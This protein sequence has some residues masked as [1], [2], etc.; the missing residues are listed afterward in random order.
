MYLRCHRNCPKRLFLI[1]PEEDGTCTILDKE[2][3]DILLEADSVDD[4]IASVME[5]ITASLKTELSASNDVTFEEGT[6]SADPRRTF[7][8]D[9]FR[10]FLLAKTQD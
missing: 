2:S 3:G 6:K 9:G 4:A 5:Y 7:L 1:N 10:D 8:D